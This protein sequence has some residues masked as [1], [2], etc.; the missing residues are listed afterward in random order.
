MRKIASLLLSMLA[1]SA[2]ANGA[3]VY[4]KPDVAIPADKPVRAII[5]DANGNTY[6]KE[7]QYNPAI[8]GVDIGDTLDVESNSIFFP[9]YDVRYLWSN[10][11]W[12]DENGY[13]WT[14]GH[15]YY[16]DHPNWHEHWNTYWNNHWSNSWHSHWKHHHADQHWRYRNHEH[17]QH[18]HNKK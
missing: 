10:G 4:L 16:Y 6:E 15:R 1:L 5:V 11:H 8:T 18:H 3:V 13:Y 12:L 2:L 17:W 7:Y 14:G 9:D